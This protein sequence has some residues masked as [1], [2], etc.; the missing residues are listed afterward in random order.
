MRGA[1][2]A[3]ITIRISDR[4]LRITGFC[5]GGAIL[6]CALLYLWSSGVFVPKYQLRIYV[7]DVSGL[8]VGAPVR[9][10]GVEVGA[11]SAIKPAGESAS[12]ERRIELVLKIDKRYR[13]AIRI[14][15]T[16]TLITGGL[17][18]NRYVSISHGFS[19]TAI[20][21]GGEIPSVPTQELTLKDFVGSLA[22]M[23]NC[24]QVEKDST[25]NK[26]QVLPEPH[27]KIKR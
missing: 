20:S 27:P 23:V 18:G 8:G 13:D 25:E 17:L 22:K 5:I 24:L 11:V 9:L 3:E 1:T 15:S 21:P 19:G 7:Q 26:T 14:D 10:D 2:M 4:A 6:V 16:A 12:H